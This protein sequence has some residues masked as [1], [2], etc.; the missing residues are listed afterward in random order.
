MTHLHQRIE[1]RVDAFTGALTDPAK[2]EFFV[3]DKDTEGRHQREHDRTHPVDGETGL[4]AIALKQWENLN[5][6]RVE[7]EMIFTATDSVTADQ[8][9]V[10]RQFV[11]ERGA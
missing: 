5:P 3:E 9:R 2:T 11:Q 10:V 1:A 7:Y 4:K 6:G 8:M